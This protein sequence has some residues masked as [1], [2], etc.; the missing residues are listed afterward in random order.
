MTDIELE[1][2]RALSS[3]KEHVEV[4]KSSSFVVYRETEDGRTLRVSVE[5]LDQGPDANLFARYA[6][7]ATAE[8]GRFAT[9]NPSDSVYGAIRH[10]HWKELDGIVDLTQTI[11]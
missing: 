11:R 9:G 7:R 4:H 2:L 10:V 1:A 3:I 5:V 8:N 6:C